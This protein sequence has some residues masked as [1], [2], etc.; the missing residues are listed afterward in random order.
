[1]TSAATR[2]R[3]RTRC[4]YPAG[5]RKLAPPGRKRCEDHK[6][7][8]RPPDNRPP[9]KPLIGKTE[10]RLF[11]K[12]LRPLT[13]LTTRGYEVIDF[14]EMI[15][16]PLQ[17]W[18]QFAVIHALELNPDGTYRFRTVLIIVARQ[19][20]KAMDI[21][22]EILTSRGFVTMADIVPGD[23]VYH[24]SGHLTR[25]TETSEIMTGR[26][27]F[28]VTTTDGRSVVADREHL[29]TVTDKRR[30]SSKGPRGNA[31]RT[32]VTETMTT[33]AMAQA[34]VSRYATGSRAS[35]ADGKKYTTNEYRFILPDQEPVRTPETE[36]PIDPYALGAWLGDGNSD[37]AG[38]TC[39]DPEIIGE[40]RKAGIPVIPAAGR[41]R[42]RLSVGGYDRTGYGRDT[43]QGKLRSLGLLGNK[44]VP[45]IY[46]TS[47]T[48]QREALL[49]GL[50]DTD[51][52]IEANRSQVEF[53][54]TLRPLADAVLYLARSLGWR[55]TLREGRATLYGKDCG[56]KYRVFFT[57]VAADPFCP[58]RLP[59][60]IARIKPADGG[61]GRTTLSIASIEPVET[62]PVRC[63]EVE[64]PDGL[65]LAG[66]DLVPTH[67]SHLKRIVSL[68]RMYMDG[69]TDILGVAQD[70][71]LA[72]KQWLQCQEA[73]HA[74]P[75]LEEEWGGV[76]N[77]N[78]DEWF[79]ASG[80]TYAIKAANE[81]AP[82]GGSNDEVNIDEL[83]VQHDW[84]AWAACSKTTN[85]RR[86]GQT[87]AMSNMGGEEAVVLN[88]L[89]DSALSGRNPAICIL[90]WSAE[91]GCELDDWD[92]VCQANPGLGPEGVV[93]EAA[94][95]S[96][97]LNEPAE[98]VRT[99]ILCQ[100]VEALNSA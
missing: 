94:L 10:P 100:K 89:R 71:S 69:A 72:R 84:K 2:A 46:L 31:V 44:H 15:G 38:F 82:R 17:P 34:G 97:I 14:A 52:T 92:Q 88:Q 56:P 77:V 87:W 23:E 20:G 45:E 8:A 63:I 68:W 65:F 21:D 95:R 90:E 42:W 76:R 50:M 40:I 47:G 27:C 1:M 49:Q 29:W 81:K 35:T 70:L 13:R 53:C 57:P 80:A 36:L 30:S 5:C 41:H 62:R 60:K 85:A 64:S 7:G 73:I 86:D 48:A 26:D 79:K 37:N 66:R 83:R 99:E 59:R 39:A 43:F 25:V 55:A 16:M 18:Q 6:P 28:Q 91:E 33:G 61:K 98:I 22:T 3:K 4:T 12:P 96:D 32:F 9:S 75:D 11:T 93:V 67:N 54:S 74:C 78:G 24:P 58:F 51:G 19:N